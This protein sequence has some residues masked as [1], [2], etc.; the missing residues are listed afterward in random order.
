MIVASIK[1][2]RWKSSDKKARDKG[3]KHNKINNCKISHL[4]NK[5]LILLLFI[6]PIVFK[7]P[8]KGS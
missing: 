8:I 6:L 2:L 1:I 3:E 5:V 7:R 4:Y